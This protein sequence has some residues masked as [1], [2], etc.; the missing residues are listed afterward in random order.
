PLTGETIGRVKDATAAEARA[1]IGQA[2][3]AFLAWRA[4][5]AP[6]RGELVRLLG[7]ALRQEKE[8]LGRLVTIEVG[9]I[10]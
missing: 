7:E 9:K 5:P 6:R 2:H 4:A 8:A 10:V 1:A 3:E